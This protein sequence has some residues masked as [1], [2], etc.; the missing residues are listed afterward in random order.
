MCGIFG[1]KSFQN[2][3]KLYLSNKQRG[4]FAGGSVY[5]SPG[6]HLCLQKWEGV[7]D[8]A[9]LTGEWAFHESYNIF[10]GHTQAPT[11]STRE[12]TD[13]TTHPFEH[14]QWV[15]AHNGVLENHELLREQYLTSTTGMYKGVT[16]DCSASPVDSSVIPGLL[17]EFYI[18]SDIK[19]IQET[20]SIIK[21]TF[22][23]WIYNKTNN[24]AYLV[25]SGSTLFGD[26]EENNFSSISVEN[27]A[28][29]SLE[30][31]VIYCI[32]PEG[33]TVVGSFH[34]CSP[35]FLF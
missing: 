2:Y 18:D 29:D 11:G 20:F 7:K 9:E 19:A 15:V 26:I 1:S 23:C 14:G 21:G 25:R 4:T 30:E 10:L 16:Y 3:E 33:L 34:Q 5:A 22:A 35:F 28:E 12:Y 17:H 31:G 24:Q 6:E 27:L 32:T 13:K 8:S